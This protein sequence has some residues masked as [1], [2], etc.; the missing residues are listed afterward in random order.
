MLQAL[1]DDN[2]MIHLVMFVSRDPKALSPD[3]DT[4]YAHL[5]MLARDPNVLLHTYEVDVDNP[6]E[7]YLMKYIEL[8]K[9]DANAV[10]VWYQGKGAWANGPNMLSTVDQLVEYAIKSD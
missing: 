1:R 4:T 8:E 5:H 6:S 10:M 2:H 9:K 3:M 7:Q